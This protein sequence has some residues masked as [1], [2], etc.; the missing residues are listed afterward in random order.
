LQRGIEKFLLNPPNRL[1]LRV[2]IAPKAFA[3]LE[4]T[5]R[6]SGRRRLTPVGNG[7][8]DGVFWVVAEHGAR[9]DYVKNLMANPKVR[10]RV[11]RRWYS[12]TAT[13]VDDDDP[14]ERRRNIDAA[15]GAIG[16]VDGRIFKASA[17]TPTTV[18]VDLQVI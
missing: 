17:S 4:T 14:F 12:G 5:G 11:G 7:L 1:A 10:A 3:L 13:I 16:K 8:A 2:G 18:R 15:N 9:C 6:R